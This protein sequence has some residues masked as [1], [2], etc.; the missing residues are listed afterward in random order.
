MR[1]R[2]QRLA[3]AGSRAER[4]PGDDRPAGE[5]VGVA[6]EQG[7]GHGA[8]GRQAGDEDPRRIEPVVRD[9]RGDGGG[10]R[11]RLAVAATGVAGLEP[12]EAAVGV[13]GADLL[14]E[15]QGEAERAGEP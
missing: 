9:D 8:P 7:I 1:H 2:R 13:V 10:D 11:R 14:G 12:V 6:G 3:D 4:Q 15:Q 5:D